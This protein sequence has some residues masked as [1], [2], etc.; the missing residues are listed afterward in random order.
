MKPLIRPIEKRDVPRV[1]ALNEEFVHYLSPMDEALLEELKETSAYFHVIDI[2]GDVAGY[3]IA[4][5]SGADYGSE[6]YQW[7]EKNAE[8]FLYID[9]VVISAAF[10]G[11]QL[12]RTFY[13]HLTAFAKAE[14]LKCLT[15]E[16][17][18][19]P[20]NEG[21]QKFHAAYGFKEISTQRLGNGTKMVS[22]Q[23][24]ASYC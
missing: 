20:L 21:S 18:L 7:F 19:E 4:F 13:D 22:M 9:R 24:Y 5:T 8:D 3:L 2:D 12:G 1:L 16:Y 15:C 14:G 6:N 10:Q 17:N 11:Q 23:Q